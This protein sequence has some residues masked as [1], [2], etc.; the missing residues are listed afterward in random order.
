[1]PSRRN[2]LAGGL[3]ALAL[4]A[5]LTGCQSVQ[6]T[7]FPVGT[8]HPAPKPPQAVIQF[9]QDTKPARHYE[10]VAKLNVHFEKTFFIP[11]S[12]D[13]ARPQLEKLAREQGADA[14]IDIVEKKSRLNETFIYNVTAN[15]VVF[16]N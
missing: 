5:G 1:M 2:K 9:F 11:T 4:A 13:E 6:P 8:R 16:T 7:A 12:M 10:V 3:L 14:L 15:A